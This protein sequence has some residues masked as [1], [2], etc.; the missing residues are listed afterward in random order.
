MAEADLRADGLYECPDCQ[1]T[2][3]SEK[4]LAFCCNPAA[5]R[6]VGARD[7]YLG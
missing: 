4:S 2:Y 3:D 6:S 7:T 5:L 1:R